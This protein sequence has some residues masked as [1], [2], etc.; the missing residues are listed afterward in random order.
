MRDGEWRRHAWR[1]LCIICALRVSLE[2]VRLFGNANPN[3]SQRREG[4]A[5]SEGV[6]SK[7][8]DSTI[9]LFYRVVV[10]SLVRVDVGWGAES[11]V[12]G[13]S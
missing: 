9:K 6:K 10:V 2:K 5:L 12:A 13:V 7:L 1:R 4:R 11:A 3:D 8:K